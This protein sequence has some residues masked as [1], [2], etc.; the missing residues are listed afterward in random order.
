MK[1]F[2]LLLF[3]LALPAS[4]SED[5]TYLFCSGL[6]NMEY[7]RKNGKEKKLNYP[8]RVYITLDEANK[9]IRLGQAHITGNWKEASFNSSTIFYEVDA[10]YGPTSLT[11]NRNTGKYILESTFKYQ[12]S[13]EWAHSAGTCTK[14][15]PKKF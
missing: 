8:H 15:A 9:R 11:I 3:L 12:G 2:F 13:N 6:T 5:Y 1:Y 7:I 4:A 14:Q 10:G